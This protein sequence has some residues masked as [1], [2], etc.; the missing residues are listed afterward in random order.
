MPRGMF[1]SRTFRR[2]FKKLPGGSTVL[3]YF[4]RKP[5]VA[6]C[7]RCGAELHGIP[8]MRASEMSKLSKTQRRPERPFG[9]VL[10]SKCLKDVL[11]YEAREEQNNGN[12]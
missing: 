7:G 12:E 4:E 9:G 10:C 3:R 8:R 6:H 11:K 2:I 5:K 1:K